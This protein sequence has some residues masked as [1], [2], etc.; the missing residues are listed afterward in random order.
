MS[1]TMPENKT[2]FEIENLLLEVFKGYK[3]YSDP[4]YGTGK[5]ID[6]V[7]KFASD[8]FYKYHFLAKEYLKLPLWGASK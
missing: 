2:A 1:Y 6:M 5:F 8:D 4:A 7:T 3:E